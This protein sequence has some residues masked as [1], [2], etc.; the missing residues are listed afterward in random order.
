MSV[1]KADGRYTNRHWDQNDSSTSSDEAEIPVVLIRNRMEWMDVYGDVLCE[2]YT[3]YLESG[4]YLFGNAFHQ[5]GSYHE[6]ANFI[7]RY[8]QPGATKSD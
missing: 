5:L 8:M 2:F 4:R 1:H 7:Y 6:F 3:R